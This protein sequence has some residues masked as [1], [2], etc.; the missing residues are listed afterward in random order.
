MCHDRKWKQFSTSLPATLWTTELLKK[1][2]WIQT[3]L[4]FTIMKHQAHCE[5]LIFLKI[6][7]GNWISSAVPSRRIYWALKFFRHSLASWFPRPP[8]WNLHELRVNISYRDLMREENSSFYPSSTTKLT[9]KFSRCAPPQD[10]SLQLR[11]RFWYQPSSTPA[12]RQF[13]KP[14]IL[15]SKLLKTSLN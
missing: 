12:L 10:F 11:Q 7:Q 15:K 1:W 13:Q 6:W 14:E 2:T 9:G 8:L 4:S 5:V 3:P